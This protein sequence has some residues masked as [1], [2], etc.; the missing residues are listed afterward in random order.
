M[1]YLCSCIYVKSSLYAEKLTWFKGTDS[2]AVKVKLTS[3]EL[4]IVCVYRSTSLQTVQENENL[5]S[6]IANIP[7][8]SDKNIILVGDINL[9]NVDWNK[10]IVVCPDN[11]IDRRFDIQNQ[12]L[13]LFIMK[14]FH[15]YVDNQATRIRKVNEQIQN[16][17]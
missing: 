4:Y 8:E 2:L 13:D 14:G 10:G 7:T 17:F 1:V 6:Q 5:L 12:Y 11:S 15:W 9:P 3:L 16:I